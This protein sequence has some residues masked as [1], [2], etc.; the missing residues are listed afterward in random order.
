MPRL[1]VPL[2]LSPRTRVILPEGAA[3]KVREVLRA[4]VGSSLTLFDGRGG[5]YPGVLEASQRDRVEVAVGE[6]V[7]VTRESPVEITLAQGI[8]RGERMDYTL[9]KAVEL[10][11][12]RIV[13]L[14][15]VRSQVKLE[16]ERA[17]RRI[18]HWQGIITHACEQS[19]RDRLPVLENIQSLPDFM[20]C[21]EATLK[22]T[23]TPT[24]QETLASAVAGKASISLVI[25]PEGGLDPQEVS[26]LEAAGYQG[27]R[28]GP[29]ILRTE[30]AALVALSVLQFVAGD[31]AQ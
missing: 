21:D 23:L 22:L 26:R 20:A 5:E 17:T 9:Q 27:V 1:F 31:L 2:T 11:V 15:S 4:R 30:T 10:G 12:T 25:G 7:E 13:P 29:R 6:R 19:G 3:H 24:A 16:G 14:A 8:S 28:L 18:A